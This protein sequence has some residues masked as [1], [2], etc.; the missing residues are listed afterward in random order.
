MN[1]SISTSNQIKSNPSSRRHTH[2]SRARTLVPHA[3]QI[4]FGEYRSARSVLSEPFECLRRLMLCL[5]PAAA[6][7]SPVER[8]FVG[9]VIAFF[10]ALFQV[11]LDEIY[12]RDLSFLVQI[13][14]L[15]SGSGLVVMRFVTV[16]FTGY[17]DV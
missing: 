12:F 2:T 8:A 11:G 9:L 10:F 14:I 16:V 13:S 3:L 1:G 5:V 4:L 15:Q 7:H 17:N 6:S